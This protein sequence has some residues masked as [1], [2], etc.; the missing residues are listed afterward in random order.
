M[1]LS[2]NP[3]GAD[4]DGNSADL[5]QR[6]S[7]TDLDK[8]IR[9]Y[10]PTDLFNTYIGSEVPDLGNI[11]AIAHDNFKSNKKFYSDLALPYLTIAL[12]S[13]DRNSKLNARRAQAVLKQ[14]TSV[15][16]VY[17]KQSAKLYTHEWVKKFPEMGL[18]LRDKQEN[19]D[20]VVSKEAHRWI[21]SI[22]KG[23]EKVDKKEKEKLQQMKDVAKNARDEGL[24]SA[25]SL[26]WAFL[27][28]RYLCSEVYLTILKEQMTGGNTSKVVMRYSC[29]LSVLDPST[30]FTKKFILV[31]QAQQLTTV[32]PSSMQAENWE[33]KTT[34]F[35][36]LLFQKFLKKYVDSQDPAIRQC[37]HEMKKALEGNDIVEYIKILLSSVHLCAQVGKVCA[38]KNCANS[39]LS[40]TLCG[41][42]EII[43]LIMEFWQLCTEKVKWDAD[44]V[45]KCF[46]VITPF[47]VFGIKSSESMKA[48]LG[49]DTEVW[50]LFLS[51][52]PVSIRFFNCFTK[53]VCPSLV[54][55]FVKRDV[56]SAGFVMQCEAS[57]EYF[58]VISD[59]DHGPRDIGI[60]FKCE[61][62][63]TSP[64]VYLIVNSDGSL[65]RG[66]LSYGYDTVLSVSTDYQGQS[67]ILTQIWKKRG[68]TDG[69]TRYVVALTLKN[70]DQLSMS[71]PISG[72]KR[73]L[74]TAT[75]VGDVNYENED[76]LKS[77]SFKI[78][79]VHSKG[80]Y[81]SVS[82]TVVTVAESPTFWTLSI[83]PMK[84]AYSPSPLP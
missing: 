67:C 55:K 35:T 79:N 69:Y 18:F 62:K 1:L 8:I 53:K 43:L 52:I 23:M 70:N 63:S 13:A 32:L 28:F 68:G 24:R 37:V 45:V 25:K 65:S 21:D 19:T 54:E 82:S 27:L 33:D 49:E 7:M 64:D 46:S 76:H 4:S 51:F 60:A 14:K 12:K 61:P 50:E 39:N 80:K 77:A 72:N 66:S 47:V 34:F 30:Y 78:E 57:V 44:F 59:I 31:M 75:C 56:I 20:K 71:V 81:L 11:E 36:E 74:W 22:E 73:Q 40:K 3:Y 29:I 10:M 5:V 58:Q 48:L 15:S 83:E 6:E 17:K 26:Y 84:P 16:D 9:Y 42:V 38:P 41:I 2:M